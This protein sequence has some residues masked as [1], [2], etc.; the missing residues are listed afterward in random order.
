MARDRAVC[1]DL[2]DAELVIRSLHDIDYFTCLYDRYERRLIRYIRKISL[3]GEDEA[4]DILQEAFIKIWR[5][6]NDYDSSMKLSSWLYR[7][8]HNETIS[9]HRRQ[10]SYGKNQ[11]VELEEYEIRDLHADIDVDPPP[12]DTF[13]LTFKILNM[14]PQKYR[15]CIVLQYFEQMSYE[16]IS[17]VLKIPEGTVAIRINRA[18]K[19]FKKIAENEHISF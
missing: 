6:L 4:R 10:I 12:E 15:E 16:D 14:M 8:V 18:K 13:A 5:N 1:K 9:H 19:L 7:I 2:E 3:A 17:D 11:V